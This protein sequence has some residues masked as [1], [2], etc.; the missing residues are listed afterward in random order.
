VNDTIFLGSNIG[1]P[2]E[3]NTQNN[4]F[5]ETRQTQAVHLKII[6]NRKAIRNKRSD[7]IVPKS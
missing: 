5:S 3:K 4:I 1:I 2:A 7:E 6:L